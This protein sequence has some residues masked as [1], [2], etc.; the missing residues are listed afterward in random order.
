MLLSPSSTAA[1]PMGV[2]PASSVGLGSSG[3]V[4]VPLEACRVAP[5]VS[6]LRLHPPAYDRLPTLPALS[7]DPALLSAAHQV[8]GRPF[9]SFLLLFRKY[10]LG[11]FFLRHSISSI[12]I[13]AKLTRAFSPSFMP[14]SPLCLSPAFTQFPLRF[15]VIVHLP[16]I[17]VHVSPLSSH[18]AAPLTSKYFIIIRGF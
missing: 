18:A 8:R 11:T 1:S 7:L 9:S 6:P 4:G 16:H 15:L 14:S 10:D 5:Y 17:L 2:M 13:T 12:F 3:G